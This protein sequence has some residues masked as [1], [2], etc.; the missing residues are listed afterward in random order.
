[1]V[2][3]KLYTIRNNLHTTELKNVY[4]SDFYCKHT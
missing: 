3:M 4:S 2:I 1:M